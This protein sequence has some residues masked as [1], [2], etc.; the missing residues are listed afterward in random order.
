VHE[1]VATILQRWLRRWDG[2]L[3][4]GRGYEVPI[5]IIQDS[6]FANTLHCML[7]KSVTCLCMEML[8]I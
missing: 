2:G 7:L 5:V 1:Y 3:Q 6:V 4:F 8:C